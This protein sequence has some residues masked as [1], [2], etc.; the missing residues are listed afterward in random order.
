MGRFASPE[1]QAALVMKSL[2]GNVLKSVRT[3]SNYEQAL[4]KV[5]QYLREKRIGS[6]QKISP[7]KA[8]TYLEQR[9]QEVGQKTLDMERQAI[10]SMMQHVTHQLKPDERLPIIK[11]EQ[12]TSLHSRAYTPEQIKLVTEH[13]SAKSALATQ[14]AYQAGIRAHELITLQKLDQQPADLRPVSIHK[15]TGRQ[16]VA[17]SVKG[18]GGLTRE[19]RIPF[20]LSQ[21]LEARAIEPINVTDRGVN[22]QQHYDL[23]GGQKWSNSFSGAS[24]RALGWSRGGHGLRHSY[25]QERMNELQTTGLSEHDA[26]ET[27]SQELGHFRPEI[28]KVYLR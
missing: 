27:V 26:L 21:Q 5:S 12:E 8:V 3:V 25:A 23:A 15:F 17:Y 16:G 1:K 20:A 7:A 19:I 11:S 4:T 18:K 6:L 22:Y 28:T 24:D 9:G 14:L 2:Q 13:Q 10:Q